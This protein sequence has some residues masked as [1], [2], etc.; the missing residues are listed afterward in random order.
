MLGGEC[1]HEHAAFLNLTW[2][3]DPLFSEHL[4]SPG[5]LFGNGPLIS[6][7]WEQHFHFG[8]FSWRLYRR[9]WK[10]MYDGGA[11][12]APQGFIK[13]NF[14]KLCIF[15]HFHQAIRDRCY[16]YHRGCFRPCYVNKHHFSVLEWMRGRIK[17]SCWKDSC[18]LCSLQGPLTFFCF[19]PKWGKY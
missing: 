7:T 19:L 11:I 4:V 10:S 13:C 15:I 2:P 8:T 12:P 6:V 16:F 5:I 3:W 17:F 18:F 1:A 9:S 14:I